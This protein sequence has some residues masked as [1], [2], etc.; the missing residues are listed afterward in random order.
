MHRDPV[1]DFATYLTQLGNGEMTGMWRLGWQ[2]DYPSIE[3]F[4][5]P[6]YAEG[7]DSNYYGPYVNEEF[8]SLLTQAAAAASLDEANALYQQAEQVIAEDMVSIPMY[9]GKA[10]IC[11]SD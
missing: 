5:A 10:V 11:W 7:A 3:N 1:V 9:Y 6:L 4:L 8:E 2:M